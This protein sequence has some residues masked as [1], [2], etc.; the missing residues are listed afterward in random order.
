MY[1]PKEY[2]KKNTNI[3]IKNKMKV[4][5]HLT[6][7]L[8]YLISINTYVSIYLTKSNKSFYFLKIY[9]L[10]YSNLKKQN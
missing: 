5:K 6:Y 4:H 8:A 1:T 2:K 3:R 7:I 9:K 10:I